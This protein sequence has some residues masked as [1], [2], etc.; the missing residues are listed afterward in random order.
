MDI[1]VIDHKMPASGGRLGGYHALD[2]G[3]EVGLG[4]GGPTER[5]YDRARHHV[6]TENEATRAVAD[7][8]KLDTFDFSRRHGQA[9]VFA[10]QGLHAAQF[11]G[12][13]RPLSLL[14]QRR[15]FSVQFTDVSDLGIEVSI[16]RGGQPIAPAVGLHIP[17][18]SSRAACRSEI[19]STMPRPLISSAISRAVHWLMGRPDRSGAWQASSTIWQTCSAVIRRGLPGRGASLKRSATGRSSRLTGPKISHRSRQSRTIS[20]LM[21][22]WRA[23]WALLYPAA[24]NSTMRARQAICWAVRWRR[25]SSSRACR[26]VSA[27]SLLG[28]LGPRIARSFPIYAMYMAPLYHSFI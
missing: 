19:S 17:L 5:S 13:H 2:M 8:L 21:L 26:S 20:R 1:Q 10:F 25:T 3:Q 7:I 28:G 22:S 14:G 6:P 4:A 23:I 24:A 18:F 9:W 15:R 12:A 16:I 27:N 11:I